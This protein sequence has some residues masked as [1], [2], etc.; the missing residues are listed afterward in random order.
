MLNKGPPLKNCLISG[1]EFRPHQ[2]LH[3]AHALEAK[4]TIIS[5]LTGL[6]SLSTANYNY[7][8]LLCIHPSFSSLP[9]VSID[10]EETYLHTPHPTH[11]TGLIVSTQCEPG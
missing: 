11:L 10:V 4:S 6:P 2:C 8:P 1:L 7:F 9:I 3:L 5:H